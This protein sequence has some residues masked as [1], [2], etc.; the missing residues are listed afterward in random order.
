M[1][2]KLAYKIRVCFLCFPFWN[3]CFGN[4]LGMDSVTESDYLMWPKLVGLRGRE[5]AEVEKGKKNRNREK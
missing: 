3:L 5:Q 1:Q 2:G 4:V